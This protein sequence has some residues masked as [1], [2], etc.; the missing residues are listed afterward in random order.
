MSGWA[1]AETSRGDGS[2]LPV[3]DVTRGLETPAHKQRKILVL[4][5]E[6]SF[7]HVILSNKNEKLIKLI[8]WCIVYVSNR[9]NLNI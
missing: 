2:G 7:K 6:M 5:T 4:I 1:V 3:T 8:K 9:F